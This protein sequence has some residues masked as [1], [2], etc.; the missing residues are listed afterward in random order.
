MK[1]KYLAIA[2]VMTATCSLASF[3]SGDETDKDYA[4]G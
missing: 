1:C 3:A 2:A 4:R